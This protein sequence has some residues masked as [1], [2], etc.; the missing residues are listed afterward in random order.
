M[1]AGEAFKSFVLMR[2]NTFV[3]VICYAG[4]KRAGETGQDVNVELVGSAHYSDILME[5]EE[6]R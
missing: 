4:V 3:E 6:K 5:W 1:I 2:P